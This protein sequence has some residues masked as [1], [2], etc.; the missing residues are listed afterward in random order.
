MPFRSLVAF[1][2]EKKMTESR[3]LSKIFHWKQTGT[4]NE[5]M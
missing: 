5:R 4:D 2:F 3:R 1:W